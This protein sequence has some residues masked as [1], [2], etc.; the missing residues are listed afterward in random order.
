M[1]VA[2][3]YDVDVSETWIIGSSYSPAG[4]VQEAGSVGVL[5]NQGSVIPAEVA[6]MAAERCDLHDGIR[7]GQQTNLSVEFRSAGMQPFSRYIFRSV[8]GLRVSTLRQT[9]DQGVMA[10]MNGAR[11]SMSRVIVQIRPYQDQ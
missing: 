11:Q 7:S 5:E 3:Q 2:D 9:A 1:H 8:C 10:K 4:V 6:V